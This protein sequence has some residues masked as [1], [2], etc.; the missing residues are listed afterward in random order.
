MN[1]L[2]SLE[3]VYRSKTY[4]A[5][6]R[7]RLNALD[8]RYQVTIMN[9]GLHSLLYGHDVLIADPRGNLRATPCDKHDDTEELLQSII[10]AFTHHLEV[11]NH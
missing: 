4:Y 2:M 10:K 6:V 9:S 1:A 8:D 7:K 3:F 11:T 5:L